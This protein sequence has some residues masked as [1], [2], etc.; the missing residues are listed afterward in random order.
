[1]E[2]SVI[3]CG[4]QVPTALRANGFDYISRLYSDHIGGLD[5]I[6]FQRYN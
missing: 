2:I 4:Y 6:A 3:D 5:F 1:M